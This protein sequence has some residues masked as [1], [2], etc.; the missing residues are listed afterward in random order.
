IEEDVS[1]RLWMLLGTGVHHV[2]DRAEVSHASA[3]ELLDA[4]AVLERLGDDTSLKVAKWLN[5]EAR[6]RFPEA[7][8]DDVI[9]EKTL[10]ITIKTDIG[11]LELSGTFDK[12]WVDLGKL[13][14]YKLTT[15]WGYIYEES[16]KKWYAQLNVY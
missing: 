15:V 6:K 16:K 8:N 9:T 4:V 14:D 2:I 5:K 10:S 3:R 1:N 11:N 13:Q 12:F 7:F